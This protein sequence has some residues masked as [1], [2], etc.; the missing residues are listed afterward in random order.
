MIL[1]AYLCQNLSFLFFPE[2]IGVQL[3]II[4]FPLHQFP[5]ISFFKD[6]AFVYYQD[7]VGGPNCR[8]PVGDD[9]TCPALQNFPDAS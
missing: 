8:E 6:L 1:G 7:P 2:L 4:A 9:K 5:V 3:I